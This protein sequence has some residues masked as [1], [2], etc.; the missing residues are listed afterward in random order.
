MDKLRFLASLL[1]LL[2]F[3]V[4]VSAGSWNTNADNVVLDG[5]DVVA[6]HTMDKAVKGSAGF[7]ATYD[8]ATFHFA[9]AENLATFK[10]DPARYA[11]KFNGYCAFAA[12]HH[13]AKVPANADTFKLYNGELLVFFNDLNEGKK[14]NTKIPWNGNEQALYTA[15][16]ENWKTLEAK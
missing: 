6:Y 4:N 14:F 10:Q 9:T 2:I 12:G 8:G 13:N 16:V 3:A 5:H 11:P 7:S 15:A 1:A